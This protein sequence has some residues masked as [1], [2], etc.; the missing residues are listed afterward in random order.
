MYITLLVV[1]EF[2]VSSFIY[3]VFEKIMGNLILW[4]SEYLKIGTGDGTEHFLPLS[5]RKEADLWS[6]V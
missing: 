1:S 6:S 5:F 2:S 3:R 4:E